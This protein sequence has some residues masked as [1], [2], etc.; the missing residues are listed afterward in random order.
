[1][2]IS[3]ASPVAD[4]SAGT[5]LP[6]A[7]AARPGDP[8]RPAAPPAAGETFEILRAGPAAA[9]SAPACIVRRALVAGGAAPDVVLVDREDLVTAL[10][11][12]CGAGWVFAPAAPAATLPAMPANMGFWDVVLPMPTP[13]PAM[14]NDV[15]FW[16]RLR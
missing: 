5:R 6:P 2:G 3:N 15:G 8:A 11:D 1:V 7:A 9:G 14:P 10:V 4:R 16:D 13:L 12:G